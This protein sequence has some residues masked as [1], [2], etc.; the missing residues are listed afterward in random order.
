MTIANLDTYK[1]KF[2]AP[3]DFA[4]YLLVSTRT[5]Y[6]WIEKGA[7]RVV[8][9]ERTVRIPIEEA[10]RFVKIDPIN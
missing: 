10:R 3:V 1:G 6:H 5:V 2:V 8:R 9:V 4:A 7:L